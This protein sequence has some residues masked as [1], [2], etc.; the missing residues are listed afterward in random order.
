[1]AQQPT[2]RGHR[3]PVEDG[4]P[5]G[6]ARPTGRPRW[7]WLL[8]I[9][10]AAAIVAGCAALTS[11]L[12][13]HDPATLPAITDHSCLSSTDLARGDTSLRHLATV[14]CDRLH[15]A[16]VF[17]L[18]TIA[19]GEDLDDVGV[20]CLEVATRLGMDS[21]AL[22]AR[23]LEVR[24]L[25]LTNREPTAGTPVACFVRQQHGTPQSGAVFSGSDR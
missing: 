12:V 24:P 16:E 8:G 5:P 18:R 6:P 15:D 4:D 21:A 13:R 23:D 25:A 7:V 1:M 10:A 2:W 14:D 22:A 3:A 19:P 20:R 17:A 11:H 9:G